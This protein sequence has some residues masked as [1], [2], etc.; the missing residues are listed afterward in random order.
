MKINCEIY[1][2]VSGYYRPIKQYN[3]AK[4]EEFYERRYLNIEEFKK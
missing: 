2:R 1:S 3:K 4:Q